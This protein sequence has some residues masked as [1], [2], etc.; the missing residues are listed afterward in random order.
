MNLDCIAQVLIENNLATAQ[1]VDIFQHHI[2][3]TVAQGLL[4]KL[5]MDGIPINH[6]MIG[7]FKGRF[8]VIQRSKNHAFGDTQSLLIN[9]ALTFYEREFTDDTGA[10]LMR[11]LNCYPSTLPIVY[12]RTKG[13]EYEWSCNF[14]CHYIMPTA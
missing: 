13:N 5:P 10:M 4:L 12:P 7:F 9:S 11:V 3:D 8:Q 1:G 2:P 14:I 6:Y